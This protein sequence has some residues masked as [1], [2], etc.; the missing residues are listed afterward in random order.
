MPLVDARDVSFDLLLAYD[1]E[2]FPAPR[3]AFLA[4][5]LGLAGHRGIAAVAEGQ[6]RGYAVIRPCPRGHKIGPLFADGPQVA[7]ALFLA[8][9]NPIA[10]QDVFL[11]VPEPN[12]PAL[13][14][15]ERW[16]LRPAFETARMYDGPAPRVRLECVY[17]VTT[18]EL[19]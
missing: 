7:E 18:F 1:R 11:D 15:A 3:P 16:G 9:T 2:H 6:L 8:L 12:G 14:L 19:G 10:G 17:G 13:V 4:G 5:W